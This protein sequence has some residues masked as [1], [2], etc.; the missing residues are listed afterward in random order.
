MFFV[1]VLLAS[2]SDSP[3][4]PNVGFSQ[5][6]KNSKWDQLYK[7]GLLMHQRGDLKG[8]ISFFQKA[9]DTDPTKPEP[10]LRLAEIFLVLNELQKSIDLSN[11]ALIINRNLPQA[12]MIK[13][14]CYKLSG[15]LTMAIS[16]YQTAVEVDPK[17]YEGYRELGLIFMGKGDSLAEFYFKNA[18]SANPS[19]NESLYDLA[20]FYIDQQNFNKAIPVLKKLLVRQ[21]EHPE[22]LYNLGY[23]Y[24]HQGNDSCVFYFKDA[25]NLTQD[26]RYPYMIG[27]NFERQEE[28][29]SAKHYYQFSLRINPE[30]EQ[31]NEA[32]RLLKK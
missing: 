3:S 31:A 7:S 2:C 11:K 8:A 18:I 9:I 27:L 28:L 16:S 6:N 17:Y 32:L 1:V 13:G 10:M 12:Y 15:N 4:N 29:D 21:P 5:D 24:F 14:T 19:A 23:A 22:A 20:Y 30:F 26:A 25:W